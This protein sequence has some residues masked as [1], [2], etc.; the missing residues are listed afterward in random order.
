MT[1]RLTYSMNVSLDGYVNDARGSLEWVSIDD[2]IHQWFNDRARES[3]LTVYGRG[4]YETMAAYW[5]FAL[6]DP[7]AGPVEREFAQIW[8]GQSKI[9]FSHTLESVEWNSRLERDDAVAVV[10]RLKSEIDG[11]IEVGGATLVGALIS[12][13]L[14]DEFALVV[15]PVVVG[16][17]TRF[18]PPLDEPLRLRLVE[19]RPFSNGAALLRYERLR[20]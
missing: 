6:D 7:D 18:F 1:A 10:R 12:A 3:A 19:A 5:P 13:D 17:G 16:D 11:E 9:V 15:Y 4:M 14:V 8:Q 20:D 2:E